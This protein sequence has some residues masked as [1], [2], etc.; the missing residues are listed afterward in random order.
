MDLVVVNIGAAPNIYMN[1]CDPNAHWVGV[2]LANRPQ[3]IGARITV[4]AG[5]SVFIREF[6]S[7]SEGLGSGGPTSLTIG[8]GELETIDSLRVQWL[9]GEVFEAE[10]VDVDR[11]YSIGRL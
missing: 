11:Y 4:K 10:S 2:T 8:I 9:T 5:G 3:P 7:G 6:G 1:G